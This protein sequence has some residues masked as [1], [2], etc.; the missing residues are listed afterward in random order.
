[1]VD[2]RITRR[3]IGSGSSTTLAFKSILSPPLFSASVMTSRRPGSIVHEITL[4]LSSNG[5][6]ESKSASSASI[7]LGLNGDPGLKSNVTR[8]TEK[9][10]WMIFFDT[11]EAWL[12]ILLSNAREETSLYNWEFEFSPTRTIRD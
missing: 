7:S 2:Q 1:M 8:S 10:L 6:L 11:I 12:I 9:K 4:S 5:A 3:A